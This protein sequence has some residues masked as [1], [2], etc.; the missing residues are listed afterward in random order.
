MITVLKDSPE[1]FTVQLL[2][3]L[4][5]ENA[6]EFYEDFLDAFGEDRHEEVVLD[7]RKIRFVDSSGIG[8]LLK[9][10]ETL[11]GKGSK[12]LMSGLNRSLT[13]VFKLAGLMKI[14]DVLEDEDAR[15]KCP[16]LF[17]ESSD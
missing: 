10:A 3:D 12:F 2:V 16:E 4:K 1:Q 5:M 15:D 11:R 9:S 7:F 14:F 8:V 17:E 13:T 6:R